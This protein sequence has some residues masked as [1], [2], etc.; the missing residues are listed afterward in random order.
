MM[1]MGMVLTSRCRH[2]A[3]GTGRVQ[4]TEHAE[5]RSPAGAGTLQGGTSRVQCTN[6]A[7]MHTNWLLDKLCRTLLSQVRLLHVSVMRQQKGA[8]CF[9]D[10]AR[11]A[12]TADQFVHLAKSEWY[13][14]RASSYL[15]LREQESIQKHTSH[16]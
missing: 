9:A 8:G 5:E 15:Q 4:S 11:Q 13:P 6:A 10:R 2:T 1:H 7:P 12:H 14:P 16:W 3:G